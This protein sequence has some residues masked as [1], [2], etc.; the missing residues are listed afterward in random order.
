MLSADEP[1]ARSAGMITDERGLVLTT[2][3]AEAARHFDTVVSHYLK[4]KWDTSA[5][6][7]KMLAADPAFAMGHALKGYL[8]MT[9]FDKRRLG[10][11]A[12]CL[13]AAREHEVG[14]TPR[15]R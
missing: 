15:E 6:S 5:W 9:A 13:A 10:A 4:Y 12:K 3:N 1:R 8:A 2:A 7:E 11:V 14:A